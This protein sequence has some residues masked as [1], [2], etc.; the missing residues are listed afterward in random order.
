MYVQVACYQ[1]QAC[2]DHWILYSCVE[3][4]FRY[5]CWGT[6]LVMLVMLPNVR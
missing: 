3:W 2:D 5:Q 1:Y 4:E 6:V